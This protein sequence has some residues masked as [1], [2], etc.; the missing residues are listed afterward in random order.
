MTGRKVLVATALL[1]MLALPAVAQDN[2]LYGNIATGIMNNKETGAGAELKYS[3]TNV[4]GRLGFAFT[5]NLAVEGEAGFTVAKDSINVSGVSA[6]VGTSHFGLFAKGSMPVSEKLSVFGRVGAIRGKVSVE[7]LGVELSESDTAAAFGLG[8]EYAL[9]ESM[10]I[11]FDVTRA[12][13]S[14]T[15]GK[16]ESMVVTVGTSIKF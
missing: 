13:F 11:R 5:Q 9:S 10:G 15:D 4:V 1:A 14:S 12:E 7:A 3:T 6:D 2:G 8:A 16:T